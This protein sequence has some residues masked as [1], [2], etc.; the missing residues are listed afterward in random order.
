MIRSII[1]NMNKD[2]IF[3]V[4]GLTL[5]IIT[6]SSLIYLTETH[7]NNQPG[8]TIGEAMDTPNPDKSITI[9]NDFNE[10]VDVRI[11]V[12]QY[13]TGEIVH[14]QSYTLDGNEEL[15]E[16]YNLNQSN[17]DGIEEYEIISTY[18]DTREI[19]AI[20]TNNCYGNAYVEITESGTLYPYYAIC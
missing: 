7:S 1:P 17:P 14:N 4:A 5:V 10:T 16:V 15:D 19:I 20:K 8:N 13:N 3:L 2:T 12:R 9:T 6:A 11:E 18:N